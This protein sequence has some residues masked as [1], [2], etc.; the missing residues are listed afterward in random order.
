[1]TKLE[2]VSYR[3]VRIRQTDAGGWLILF[4]APATEIDAWAGIP[5]KKEIGSQETTGFQREE[6]G[7]RINELVEF[8]SSDKNVI[9][10]PLLCATRVANPEVVHFEPDPEAN[11]SPFAE[12]GTLSIQI[13]PLK[14]LTLLELLRRVKADLEQRVPSLTTQKPSDRLLVELKQRTD[15][16]VT[17]QDAETDIDFAEEEELEAS[18]FS[19]NSD[20]QEPTGVVFSDE[21]HILDFWEEVAAR[22][23]ILEE[24]GSSFEGEQFLE[25]S[26]DAMISF[27]RPIV[28]VDGQHRLR[29][30]VNSA[31]F[32]AEKPPYSEELEQAVIS[33]ADPNQAQ[34]QIE[35]KIARRL[36]ISLL[37]TDDPAEHV[38]QFVVVNQK[39]TPIGKALLGTIVSTS[40]SNDELAR[41]SKRLEDAGIQLEESRAVAYFTRNPDSP[42]FNK[43]ERGLTSATSE[44]KDLLQWSVLL[45]LVQIFQDLKGGKLFGEKNDYA[46]IW[47]ENHLERSGLVADYETHGFSTPFE[48]W[49]QLDGPWRDVFSEFWKKIR[50]KFANTNDEGASNYWGSPK[51]SNIFNKVSLTILVADFFQVLCDRRYSI[52]DIQHVSKLVDDWLDGVDPS[53][54][55]K[56]WQL[57][58]VRK[59]A[60]ARRKQWAKIW[61]DY[62]KN[63]KSLPKANLYRLEIKD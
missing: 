46:Q 18:E 37:I 52:D 38:F 50:D 16:I 8:Y 28:V 62:R 23:K 36:P 29:G 27:L 1:M 57:K 22:V 53:Y 3:A 49:R 40:L 21:S 32:L 34:Q 51:S 55:N 35:A 42:F 5:Q 12:T 59:D 44:N 47:K 7:K 33:G 30:A 9:Q 48:Y 61:T 11:Q 39:A 45:Q 24:I 10:N 20:I 17:S 2:S 43:V 58:G 31:K 60:P 6:N 25:Y 13:E 19:D 56:D 14:Q 15:F 41:V 63:P 26:K 4:A 54:F